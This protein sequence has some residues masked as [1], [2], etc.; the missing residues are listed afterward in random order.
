[1]DKKAVKR[2]EH[3]LTVIA[4][5]KFSDYFLV[6]Y[7]IVNFAKRNNIPVEVRG[8]AAGSLVSYVLG[9]TRVCPIENNLYFERFMNPGRKDCPDI[10]ID[11]CW[12]RRDDVIE[13]CY[14]NWGSE[15][16]AMIS[17]INRYRQKSA[18]RD[19]A[20]ACGLEPVEVNRLVKE[21]KARTDSPVYGL[22]DKI[23]GIPRH[24]GVHCG[25]IVITP[26]PVRDIVPL[27]RA[28][29][30]VVIT[31]YDKDAAE[32]VG[33]IKIDLLG[34]RALSTVNEAVN[35]VRRNQSGLDIDLIGPTDKKRQRC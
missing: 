22:A 29:K 26:S 31:Q 1:M 6:V 14:D 12:R 27:E 23:L 20:R 2:L 33:L 16:V 3:E 35:I 8:S 21:R 25:G 15:H 7:D 4:K 24:L 9:F 11:L 28:N 5:N 19:T 34:N 18:I 17:N 13:Y 10:D 32:A 30:G